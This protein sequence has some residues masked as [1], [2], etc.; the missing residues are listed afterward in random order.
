[1]ADGVIT[2]FYTKYEFGWSSDTIGYYFSTVRLS[3]LL[4]PLPTT[5]HYTHNLLFFRQGSS[6]QIVSMTLVPYL[7]I[8]MSGRDVSDI[9]WIL[10][11]YAARFG[12]P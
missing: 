4:L 8:K 9:Y 5:S 2:I 10:V 3:V 6:L 1:M 7:F 11:G 12:L